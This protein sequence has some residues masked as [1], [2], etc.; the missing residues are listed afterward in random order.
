VQAGSYR[1][2][3]D[4]AYIIPRSHPTEKL[5]PIVPE[6]ERLLGPA[7]PTKEVFEA[8]DRQYREDGKPAVW[9]LP[10][11]QPIAPHLDELLGKPS[12]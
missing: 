9:T 3:R 6:V 7:K 1:K 11:N 12:G 5:S 4:R 8:L 10:L 2:D